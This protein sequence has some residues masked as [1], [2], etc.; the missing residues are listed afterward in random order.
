MRTLGLILARGGSK[1]LPM[2]NIKMLLDRPLIAWSIHSALKTPTIDK[3]L[4]STDSA[5]IQ[6]VA[7]DSGAEAPFLRPEELSSDKATSVDAALHALDYAEKQWGK[8]DA[9][10]LLEPTSPLRQRKDL[11]AGIELLKNNFEAADGVVSLGKIHLENPLYCKTIKKGLLESIKG[12]TEGAE[13]FF[14]YG[15]MYL[16]KAEVLK[17]KKVF[18]GEKMLP[19]L[20]ERWQ[21]YEVD[22]IYD[23]MCIETILKNKLNEVL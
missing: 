10:L 9:V 18:Y 21:N 19:Y 4:V 15:V 16:I 23:F 8:F 17:S 11:A 2:K 1:R 6:K 5:E 7:Q 14:P 13:Y 3:V 20:I 22:D 12:L